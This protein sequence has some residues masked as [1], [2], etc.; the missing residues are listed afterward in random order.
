M[1]LKWAGESCLL[2]TPLRLFNLNKCSLPFACRSFLT[3]NLPC[4]KSILSRQ[5][6]T[7]LKAWATSVFV[8]SLRLRAQHY[9]AKN[10][11]S[12]VNKTGFDIK[13]IKSLT[14]VASE[15]GQPTSIYPLQFFHLNST[16][17]IEGD[18]WVHGVLLWAANANRWLVTR[19]PA[20]QTFYTV[21]TRWKTTKRRF[22]LFILWCFIY[23][24][25]FV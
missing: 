10:G 9:G 13:T 14:A 3:H 1:C 25:I 6:N 23:K 24:S 20:N 12:Q 19:A 7:Q 5:H 4:C 16:S 15:T 18:I 17:Y 2:H 22:C 11:R 21:N 8:V